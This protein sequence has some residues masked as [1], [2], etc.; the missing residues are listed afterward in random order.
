MQT[1]APNVAPRSVLTFVWPAT[2]ASRSL[3]RRSA[4]RASHRHAQ[5][6]ADL[7]HRSVAR[8]TTP[9][10]SHNIRFG[11]I[12]NMQG[13][14]THTLR[15]SRTDWHVLGGAQGKSI[16]PEDPGKTRRSVERDLAPT[17]N[18]LDHGGPPRAHYV[19]A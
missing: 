18:L 3:D 15:D 17:R 2:P 11:Q 7:F 16:E 12:D 8:G 9:R 14:P 6:S 13:K 10:I 19:F 5:L 1:G 4:W